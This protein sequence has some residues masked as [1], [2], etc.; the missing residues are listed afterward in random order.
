MLRAFAQL[1]TKVVTFLGL[2]PDEQCTPTIELLDQANE[3]HLFYRSRSTD[4][5]VFYSP[6]VSGHGENKFHPEQR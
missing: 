1:S 5:W 4:R 3:P 2:V 6:S